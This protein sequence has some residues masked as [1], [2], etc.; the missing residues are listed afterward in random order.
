MSDARADG[1]PPPVAPPLV[2]IVGKKKSGKTTVIERLVAELVRR[3][4][5]VGTI[6]H[7]HHFDLD[8][9]GKDSW[10]HR[11]AG[12]ERVVLAGPDGHAVVGSWP[13][14]RPVGPVELAARHLHDLD[15]VVVEGFKLEDVPK[16]EIF[17]KSAHPEPV[18]APGSE[19]AVRLLAVVTDDD[20]H[21]RA[22]SCPTFAPDLPDLPARLAE[23]VEDRLLDPAAG[24][25]ASDGD[26]TGVD[27]TDD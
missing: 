12:S 25:A 6:K 7:G 23:L 22:L 2:A 9:E 4:W 10:R 18:F 20:G 16:I 3:G 5:R 24:G 26:A 27:A 19:G 15:I 11:A 21:A 8:T 14:G 17:R 13:L 1:P